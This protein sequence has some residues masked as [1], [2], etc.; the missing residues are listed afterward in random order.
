MTAP[1]RIVFL[2]TAQGERLTGAPR[3]VHQLVSRLDRARFAPTFVT[4]GPTELSR[5]LEEDGV[6]VRTVPLPAGLDVY[7]Q[8]LTRPGPLRAIGALGG[9][10]AYNR[11]LARL[12]REIQP[13]LIWVSNLRTFLAVFPAAGRCRIPVVWN[14]WLGQPSR[15]V[16]RL[17][18]GFA[19]R[20]ARRVVTEYRAQAAEIFT[21]A[22]KER[23][24]AKLRTVYTGHPVPEAPTRPGR[25]TP[26]APLRV[27]VLA[28]FSPRKNQRLFLESARLVREASPGVQFLLGGEAATDAERGYEVELHAFAQCAG[29]PVEWCGWVDPPQG[30]LDRLDVYVQTSE[31]EGLPGAVREAMLAG[32]PVVA[33]RVG[34]TEEIVVPGETGF[35]V[36]RG[37]ARGLAD[38]ILQLQSDPELARRMGEAGRRRAEEHFSRES[39]LAHY[40]DVL[41]EALV[42]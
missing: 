24:S 32:L 26:D 19:L 17:M 8:A 41:D 10:V 3:M 33:T 28:A 4:P 6:P 9:L 34:G 23:A 11:R 16:V 29:L 31:H 27:G 1:H 21:V 22:Q 7:G 38:A 20:R 14:I 5:R 12:F 36:E 37:D 15:G 2:H 13:E 30:F 35:L 25:T 18:N 39:F 40:Q 42:G